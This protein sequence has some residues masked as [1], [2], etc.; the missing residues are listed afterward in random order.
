VTGSATGSARGRLLVPGSALLWGLQF[1][2]LV[3]ALALLLVSLYDATPAEVGWVLAVYN[4]AGFVAAL[5]V[6]SWA[7]RRGDYLVP[8]LGCAVLTL[9]LAGALWSVT[10]LPLA[11]VA[12]VVFGAPAGV[13]VSLLFAHLRHE[14][15]GTPEVTRV[16]AVVSF[17]WIAGPPLATFL[18]ASA[19]ARA[20]LPALA[21]LAVLNGVTTLGLLARRRRNAQS[22]GA[23]PGPPDDA[24]SVSRAGVLLVALGFVLLQAANATVV[25]VMALFTTRDLGIDVVWSG[26]ALGVAAAAEIPAL[27]ALGRLGGRSSDLALV[28]SGSVVGVAYFLLMAVVTG[29]VGLVAVQ[30]LNA[31]SFAVIAGTGLGLF[32]RIVARP[33]LASGL[34][35]NTRRL[36]GVVS[37][38]V[39]GL[40]GATALGYGAAFLVCAALTAVG[41]LLVVVAL[42]A[43]RAPAPVSAGA[44]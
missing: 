2:V 10:A 27:L 24:I 42:R 16:R 7:D 34:Y 19:G 28:V 33:G 15:A 37:G 14:G 12:L 23:T 29:P 1:A 32:Q 11:V 26:V 35:A 5:V 9:L 3:P 25:S 13:G 41:L 22:G 31:W 4:G 8:M 18:I 30:L 36:G 44:R 38:P 43:A 17:A 40:G 6:P 21:V 39:I 20:L